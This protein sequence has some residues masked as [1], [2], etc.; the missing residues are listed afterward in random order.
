MSLF[1]IAIGKI[2]KYINSNALKATKG[3]CTWHK[4]EPW[5]LKLQLKH[6]CNCIS[7]IVW[8][9]K[10]KMAVLTHV[11]SVKLTARLYN[12]TQGIENQIRVVDMYLLISSL[13]VIM[14]M[15]SHMLTR[16]YCYDK[17]CWC[18]LT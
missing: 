2:L 9:K 12:M 11:Q 14:T 13:F 4:I 17:T 6:T 16:F 8:A 3:S 10:M 7:T 5:H 18:T 1:I 15:P